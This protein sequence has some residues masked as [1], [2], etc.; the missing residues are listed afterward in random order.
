MN[1]KLGRASHFSEQGKADLD[2]QGTA[3]VA[4][5]IPL[6]PKAPQPRTAHL[7]CEITDLDQQTVSQSSDFTIHSSDFYLGIRHPRD[8]VHEGEAL[9]VD[10]IAV[11]TDG[12]PTPEP[13]EAT[14]RLTRVDWQN[15]RVETAGGWPRHGKRS[16]RRPTWPSSGSRGRCWPAPSST[17][18]AIC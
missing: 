1:E 9:P 4:A 2:V 13:V 18:R 3:K 14:I 7:L 17:A 11:R 5:T 10:V 16:T 15:N 6:N 12:T 8:V